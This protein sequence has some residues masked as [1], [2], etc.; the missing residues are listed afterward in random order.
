MAA[1][2]AK[3]AITIRPT[4]LERRVVG[5]AGMAAMWAMMA[6]VASVAVVDWMAVEMVEVDVVAAAAIPL[7]IGSPA[8]P[9]E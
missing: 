3:I 2:H 5:R 9:A 6:A 1:S 7:L 4:K 8:T